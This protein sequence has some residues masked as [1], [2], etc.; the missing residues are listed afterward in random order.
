[1]LTKYGLTLWSCSMTIIVLF[2]SQNLY[3]NAQH[4]TLGLSHISWTWSTTEV[5][6]NLL[7]SRL[8]TSCEQKLGDRAFSITTP[9]TE[10]PLT[11]TSVNI[12]T[13]RITW[14]FEDIF[15]WRSILFLTLLN[16]VRYEQ[17]LLK[18]LC[19]DDDAECNVMVR[20]NS[21]SNHWWSIRPCETYTVLM[22]TRRHGQWGG[23]CAPWKCCKVFRAAN[24]V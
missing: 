4:T 10:Q 12:F 9:C 7:P 24:V 20:C 17:L 3:S 14:T 1:M 21:C 15:V 18:L 22:C 2:Y 19:D 13:H 6:F 5:V 23:T 8:P 16:F 11:F